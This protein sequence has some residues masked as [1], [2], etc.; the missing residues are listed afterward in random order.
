MET[1]RVA[2]RVPQLERRRV[3]GHGWRGQGRLCNLQHFP[4]GV[5]RST[6]CVCVCVCAHVCLCVYVDVRD[7]SGCESDRKR[8][9]GLCDGWW[10]VWA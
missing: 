1:G 6:W 9:C 4:H 8:W 7:L 10:E 2:Q 5:W 3:C